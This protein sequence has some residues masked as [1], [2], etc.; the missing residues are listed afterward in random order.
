MS[1]SGPSQKKSGGVKSRLIL[2]MVLITAI[3]LILLTI[4]SYESTIKRSVADAEEINLKQVTIIEGDILDII[5]QSF[6]AIEAAANNPG[7]R[8][9]VKMSEAEREGQLD[10]MAAYLATIDASCG[11][12]N[13]TVISDATGQNL[14]RSKGNYTNV[15]ERGY[16]KTAIAG[17][18]NLS[19][20]SVS[21]TTGS[22]I[23]VP[24]V[25]IY[26]EDGKTPIGTVTRNFDISILHDFLAAEADSHQQLLICGVNGVVIADS[27]QEIT[28]DMEDDDRSGTEYYKNAQTAEGSMIIEVDG[29]KSIVSYLKEPTT[30]WTVINI[31]D[32]KSTMASATS[33]AMIQI[34]LSLVALIIAVVVAFL[35]ANNFVAP[36]QAANRS[37]TKLAEGEFVEMDAKFLKRSDEFGEMASEVHQVIE[38]LSVI[39]ADIKS[40][41]ATITGSADDL[42]DT[43]A[44]IS[45]TADDVANAVQEI[46]SG[47]TQQAD[48]I[49]HATENTG[50]ISENLRSVMDNTEQLDTIAQNMNNNSKAS[51][52]DL[53]KLRASSEQMKAAIEEISEKIGA[54][55]RAVSVI[56]TKVEAINSIASQTNLL[57]LNASIE[58]ARAGD[59]GRG[60]AVVAQEIGTLADDSSKAAV[61]IRKEMENLLKESQA[62]V[63]QAGTVHETMEEQNEIL[64][65]TVESVNVL[66]GD[67]QTTVS[68]VQE[69]TDATE[70]CDKET[71]QVVD[72]MNSLS[73]ISQENAAASEETGASMEELNATVNTLASAAQSLKDI[74]EQLTEEMGFF[75]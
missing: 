44:Q 68:G 43:S 57:A 12:S 73:A 53:E 30:G 70:K 35:M 23:V 13:S 54:T 34:V 42:A 55:S 60:F 15:G 3:P 58:A 45:Q 9:F 49:Q 16:F 74:A 50:V 26:D 75:K 7:T 56:N 11:D 67:I 28:A 48:E 63:E 10:R 38:K 18:A 32:Y 46:A 66:I 19:E 62:A 20:V 25:P 31:R 64:S 6:R 8:D 17:T 41:T 71:V 1:A 51:I 24:A 2:T 33:G 27:K 69:I 39:V 59:A 29:V 22:R 61:D 72:A 47:A 52:Q 4:I 5:N 37:L 36:I 14:A 65:A 40:S 21:K